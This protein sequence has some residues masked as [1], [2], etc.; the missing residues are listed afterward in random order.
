[1][2][3]SN[4]YRFKHNV[5]TLLYFELIIVYK[6]RYPFI[7]IEVTLYWYANVIAAQKWPFKID[8]W[9]LCQVYASHFYNQVTLV[10]TSWQFIYHFLPVDSQFS[11][12][13]SQEYHVYFVSVCKKSR[14]NVVFKGNK[15]YVTPAKYYSLP[16]YTYK[17][18]R[19]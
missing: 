17:Y 9:K 4:I 19:A 3:R 10:Y 16:I 6:H 2:I 15:S 1:M 5:G 18:L 8:Y 11:E 7:L 14:P 12:E 13:R